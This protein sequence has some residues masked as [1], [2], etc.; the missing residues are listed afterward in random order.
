MIK[1]NIE[2]IEIPDNLPEEKKSMLLE[3]KAAITAYNE[4][5]DFSKSDYVLSCDIGG[6][7]VFGKIGINSYSK[8]S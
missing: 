4:I 3:M 5:E 8:K 6:F 1:D 2:E 7:M